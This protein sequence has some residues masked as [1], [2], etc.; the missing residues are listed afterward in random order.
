MERIWWELI[1]G[2][3]FCPI[4]PLELGI[5]ENWKAK[6][7][8]PLFETRPARGRQLFQ[9]FSASIY[10]TI[11]FI[12]V[13]RVSYF[14]AT[15]AKA[16]RWTWLGLFLAE[17]WF[18]FYWSLTLIFKWNPVFRYTFKHR[19]SS[20]LSN[21]SIKLILVTT[22]DPGIELPIMVINTVLSVMAY[23][24]PPEKLSVHLSDDGCSDLIFYALLEAASFSQIRLPF[25]RKLK[26]EPRLP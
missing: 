1:S 16:E 19:L 15:E 8:L 7:Y 17:L 21:S 22:A 4:S 12:W 5:M 10:I 6:V 25:C 11:C 3:S 24:Y 14:P 18:S 23:D 20:S 13:Y 26:V 9:L 2:Q